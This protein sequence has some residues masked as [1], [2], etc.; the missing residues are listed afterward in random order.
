MSELAANLV[1]AWGLRCTGKLGMRD[2]R[3]WGCC[4]FAVGRWRSG[5]KEEC[6]RSGSTK[7]GPAWQR[8][9]QQSSP[10]SAC[11]GSLQGNNNRQRVQPTDALW[12]PRGGFIMGTCPLG[13]PSG[14]NRDHAQVP[15]TQFLNNTWMEGPSMSPISANLQSVIMR[16]TPS[17]TQLPCPPHVSQAL[18]SGL[19]FE[20]NP[21]SRA[22]PARPDSSQVGVL[23]AAAEE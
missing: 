3:A 23:R 17:S 4:G 11:P 16:P 18:P 10:A 7:L 20:T 21:A 9:H 6:G 19:S 15:S 13:A 5:R 1:S 2:A 8:H 14:N 22:R 12:S